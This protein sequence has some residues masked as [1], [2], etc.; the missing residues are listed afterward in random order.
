V[1]GVKFLVGLRKLFYVTIGF[2]IYLLVRLY[3]FSLRVEFRNKA[4]LESACASSPNKQV[5]FVFWHCN[6]AAI[7]FGL[8]QFRLSP[9]VSLAGD[10]EITATV[11]RLLGQHPIRGGSKRGGSEALFTSARQ[12]RAGNRSSI[13]A[14]D[15]SGGP[16]FQPK[17]GC[18]LLAR[19]TGSPILPV[20]AHADSHWIVPGSWD[21]SRFPL[22][23]RT[24][25]VSFGE[26]VSSLPEEGRA[27]R[28]AAALN[29]LEPQMESVPMTMPNLEEAPE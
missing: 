2:F 11:L 24:I 6:M 7:T 14:V 29:A 16:A 22:P 26:I 3:A 8:R 13:I 15:G 9:I 27:A 28:L 20:S 19:L 12:L 21:R 23:F 25:Q 18:F 5:I 4:A 10:G 17:E 1:T